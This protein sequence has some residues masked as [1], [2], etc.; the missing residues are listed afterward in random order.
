MRYTRRAR[1]FRQLYYCY[2]WALKMEPQDVKGKGGAYRTTYQ[3][4]LE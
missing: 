2:V 1:W 3:R 4:Y